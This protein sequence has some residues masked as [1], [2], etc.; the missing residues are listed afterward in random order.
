MIIPNKLL[1]YGIG[2]LAIV[3]GIWGYGRYQYAQGVS[4][5]RAE[6]QERAIALSIAQQE[7]ADRREAEYRGRILAREAEAKK[8]AAS[9]S[10]AQRMLGTLRTKL[11]TTGTC[12]R[13]DATGT[14]DWLGII[15]ESWAE[16]QRMANEAARLTDKVTGLQGYINAIVSPHVEAQ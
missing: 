4:H 11:Q 1:A 14:D 2:A 7:A 15:G 5:E 10:D 13:L 8:F 3:A 12:P 16:Y 6:A 9:L